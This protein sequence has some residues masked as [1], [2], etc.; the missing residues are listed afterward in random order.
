[1]ALGDRRIE[2]LLKNAA[3]IAIEAFRMGRARA[4]PR[5]TFWVVIVR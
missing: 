3:A 1:M 2:E 5:A 4:S